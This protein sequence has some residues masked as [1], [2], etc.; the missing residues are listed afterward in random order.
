MRLK[1]KVL[2]FDI[3]CE[4][5]TILIFQPFLFDNKFYENNNLFVILSI[6]KP[7]WVHVKSYTKIGSAVLTF[8][9]YKVYT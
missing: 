3:S 1:Q 2:N 4:Y 5:T 6:H 7:S 8:T 9:G